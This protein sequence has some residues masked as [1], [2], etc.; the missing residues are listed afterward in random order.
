MVVVSRARLPSVVRQGCPAPSEVLFKRRADMAGLSAE[1]DE[2]SNSFSATRCGAVERKDL[3]I[4]VR[5]ALCVLRRVNERSGCVGFQSV[6]FESQ[7]VAS[8]SVSV[9][10][11][12]EC[13]AYAFPAY[14]YRVASASQ[15][16]AFAS[17]RGESP[18]STLP[19][20]LKSLARRAAAAKVSRRWRRLEDASSRVLSSG[21][22]SK[23]GQHSDGS[24]SKA[25]EFVSSSGRVASVASGGVPVGVP[26]S[27]ALRRVSRVCPVPESQIFQ[28]QSQS[29]NVSRESLCRAL[30]AH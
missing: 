14:R 1:G 30:F 29:P 16:T 9:A 21:L 18:S 25:S 26:Y 10:F 27:K 28:S 8:A 15:S 22:V 19:L 6:A 17:A 7:S 5:S 20:V 23:V 12:S 24:A 13:Q 11:Q 2:A 3:R 4:P